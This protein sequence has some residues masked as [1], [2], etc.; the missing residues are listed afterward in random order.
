MGYPKVILLAFT[1][2]SKAKL[3]SMEGSCVCTS[4]YVYGY[5]SAPEHPMLR[6]MVFTLR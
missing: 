1:N 3:S 4:S 5:H 6:E 2:R